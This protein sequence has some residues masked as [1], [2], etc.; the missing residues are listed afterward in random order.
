MPLKR[1]RE[2]FS[3]PD[4]FFELK[5]NGFRALAFVQSAWAIGYGLA[6]L[7]NLIVMPLWGWRGVFFIGVIDTVVGR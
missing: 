4:W 2:P 3:H 7:V 6:A 5:H 1:H